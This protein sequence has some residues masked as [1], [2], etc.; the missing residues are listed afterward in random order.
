MSA[1]F[2]I[3]ENTPIATVLYYVTN[4]ATLSELQRGNVPLDYSGVKVSWHVYK[5]QELI[6]KQVPYNFLNDCIVKLQIYGNC[7]GVFVFIPYIIEK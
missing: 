4:K 3:C 2:V 7:S 5:H 6:A 1:T